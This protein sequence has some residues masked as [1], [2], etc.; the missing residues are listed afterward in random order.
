MASLLQLVSKM[1]ILLN[2]PYLV[3]MLIQGT[4]LVKNSQKYADVIY[5]WPLTL[6]VDLSAV[7][8]KMLVNTITKLQD[9]ADFFFKYIRICLGSKQGSKCA[10]VIYEW[11]LMALASSTLPNTRLYKCEK[12]QPMMLFL[13]T[14]RRGPRNFYVVVLNKGQ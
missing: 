10:Y 8:C 7:I 4:Y 14:S 12:I 9:L 6:C 13:T 5:E 3:N 2:R 1:L 11:Y